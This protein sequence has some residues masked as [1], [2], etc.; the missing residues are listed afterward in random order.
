VDDN[1]AM[2]ET[3]E[4]AETT[5]ISEGIEAG[6]V[7]V[8]T[9]T[10][11]I[12]GTEVTTEVIVT[13]DTAVIE[14]NIVTTVITGTEVITNVDESSDTSSTTE[15]AVITDTAELPTEAESGEAEVDV[16]V[17]PVA[18][19]ATP[20]VVVQVTRVVTD[21]EI[22][23]DTIEVTA[24]ATPQPGQGST[25]VDAVVVFIGIEGAAGNSMRAS[26][27]LES[28]FESPDGEVAGEIQDLVIDMQTGQVLYVL[29]EYGGVLDVGD[30]DMP[31][32]LSA[33]SW[34]GDEEFIL[35]IESERLENFPGV[36][37]DWP[38][39]NNAEWDNDVRGFWGDEGFDIDFEA[40]ESAERVARVSNIIGGPI[41]DAGFGEGRVEDMIIAL[42]QGRV[43]YV[44]VSLDAAGDWYAVPLSAFEASAADN[45]F[46][47][48]PDFD[49]ALI[50]G[51][52]RFNL[53]AD[54][55]NRVFA[56]DYDSDWNDFWGEAG[57]PLD[58]DVND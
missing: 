35:N 10:E 26:T 50:E 48:D 55:Q 52:P 23:T 30:T 53:E 12:T 58:D 41:G 4:A 39:L 14:Q 32:P 33:F 43:T 27:L 2:T 46:G 38:E 15:S 47:F 24:V 29:I 36:S 20:T 6:Q 51:A 56:E 11:L 42:E 5:G 44:L 49:P 34:G 40:A 7:T 19:T 22:V 16:D 45:A 3:L 9:D 21:T 8:I 37:N 25:D 31:V 28:E 13:T 1:D 18:P 57:Y 54:G 17:T